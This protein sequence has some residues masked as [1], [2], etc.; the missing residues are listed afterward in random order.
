MSGSYSATGTS[1][2]RCNRVQPVHIKQCSDNAYILHGA[3]GF[4]LSTSKYTLTSTS[5]Q[6]S[7][8]KLSHG[9]RRP[10][11]S[12]VAPLLGR[13]S[14]LLLLFAHKTQWVLAVSG[15]IAMLCLADLVLTRISRS[16]VYTSRY[17]TTCLCYWAGSTC[18]CY[19]SHAWYSGTGAAAS[20][21]YRKACSM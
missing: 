1:H 4:S 13:F 14:L 21:T 15:S 3:G 18:C 5:S 17:R 2:I 9:P 19:C 10:D 16:N 12:T 11:C 20:E 8:Q 6:L 7:N